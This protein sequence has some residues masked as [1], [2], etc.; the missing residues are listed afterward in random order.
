MLGTDVGLAFITQTL[1]VAPSSSVSRHLSIKST[2]Q[3]Q[4][5]ELLYVGCC[6]HTHTHIQQVLA[7]S[8]KLCC[9]RRCIVS[10]DS[11]KVSATVSTPDIF[12]FSLQQADCSSILQMYVP[13]TVAVTPSSELQQHAHNSGFHHQQK[14]FTVIILIVIPP[15][16]QYYND[17]N[18]FQRFVINDNHGG[19]IKKHSLNYSHNSLYLLILLLILIAVHSTLFVQLQGPTVFLCCVSAGRHRSLNVPLHNPCIFSPIHRF[20]KHVQTIS[21]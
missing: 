8:S 7:M 13:R 18:L 4:T 10:H 17:N 2:Q 20:L 3:R 1:A 5:S 21:T 6:T 14:L 12:T 9:L 15:I 19:G 11:V 16:S